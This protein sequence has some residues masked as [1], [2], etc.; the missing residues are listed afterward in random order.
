[1]HPLSDYLTIKAAA[2]FLGVNAMTLRRWDKAGRLK[3]Y[4]NPLNGYRLYKKDELQALLEE[5]EVSRKGDVERRALNQ[6]FSRDSGE[7]VKID[8][9]TI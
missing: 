4:R 9:W 7:R 5:V 3:A 2:A 8:T 6:E 1:M